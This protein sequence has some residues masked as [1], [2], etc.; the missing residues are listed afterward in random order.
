MTELQLVQLEDYCIG[1]F[2]AMASPCE[3][4]VDSQDAVLARHLASIA[5]QEALR[6]E[7]KFSRYRQDNIVYEINNSGGKK[8]TVD[9]ETAHLLN[10]ANECYELS[11][12][13]FDVTSGILRQAW[14]FDG[15]DRI[16]GVD[17]VNK[18]LRYI[19]W[20]KVRWRSPT[21]VLP[22]GMEI[23]LGGIGKE[24][25][26]DRVAQLLSKES[27]V[28]CL[29]NFGGDLNANRER[30][31]GQAWIVGVESV[32]ASASG[33]VASSI[34]ELKRGAMATS[35]DARRFLLKNGKRY[36]HILNPLTG[37][38]VDDAP[39]SVTVVAPSCTEAGI[40]ATLAMLHGSEAESFLQQ[41][42]VKYWCI[43]D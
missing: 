23:D 32:Q 6:I 1:R 3:I 40:L 21:I 38:P 19:G 27:S 12:G 7:A 18:L 16:P 15:S 24:Y 42:D 2:Q 20:T 31:N 14:K 13:M 9:S 41:Q 5:Q 33:P 11:D 25:A 43:R 30:V 29:T 22:A 36:S 10:Y 4:L 39:R 34:L 26:V 35:G 28:A 17:Q 8:I 37:W